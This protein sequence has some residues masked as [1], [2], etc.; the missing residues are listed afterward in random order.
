VHATRP[1][2]TDIS[3]VRF[4]AFYSNVKVPLGRQECCALLIIFQYYWP[5]SCNIAGLRSILG[6]S[7]EVWQTQ[8]TVLYSVLDSLWTIP[9]IIQS[10]TFCLP[11]SK[12]ILSERSSFRVSVWLNSSYAFFILSKYILCLYLKIDL[13]W[14]LLH[15]FQSLLK[16]S[17]YSVVH[18]LWRW[19]GLLNNAG[20]HE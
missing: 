10:V 4:K 1:R 8:Y 18:V 3:K 12:H 19:I 5:S 11:S 13:D 14:F 20:I 17:S 2:N 7:N 15:P 16:K 6:Q 9:R